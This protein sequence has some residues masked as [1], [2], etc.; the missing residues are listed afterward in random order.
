MAN[1]KFVLEPGF[2]DTH[3]AQVRA[4]HI[5]A[6]KMADRVRDDMEEIWDQRRGFG[7]W[8]RRKKAWK[9]NDNFVRWFGD[10]AVT[11]E[12]IRVTRKRIIE[13]EKRFGKRLTYVLKGAGGHCDPGVW[14]WHAGGIQ[15]RR[16]RICPPFYFDEPV[17]S[18]EIDRQASVLIHEMAHGFGQVKIPG[19]PAHLIPGTGHPNKTDTRAEALDLARDHPRKARRSPENYEHLYLNYGGK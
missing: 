1:L 11:K 12:Q 15:A 3:V 17:S 8:K 14:A 6:R 2:N 5:R 4:A 19:V 13:I 18:A 16:I 7:K 9:R 10:D